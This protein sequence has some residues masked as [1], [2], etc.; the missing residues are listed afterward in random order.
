MQSDTVDSK[1]A[2]LF[3]KYGDQPYAA[4]AMK[5]VEQ[6]RRDAQNMGFYI[7]AA[8]FGVNELVR[9]TMRTRKQ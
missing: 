1:L 6:I 5:E 7:S 3:E 2:T 8:T 9:L 4:N